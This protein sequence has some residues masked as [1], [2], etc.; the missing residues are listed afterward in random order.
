[1]KIHVLAAV[2]LGVIV[3]GSHANAASISIL[4]FS[5]ESPTTNN[6]GVSG[7]SVP[8]WAYS[9]STNASGVYAPTSTQYGGVNPFDG[10]Q[11]AYLQETST[12]TISQVLATTVAPN[13]VYTLS[14]LLGIRN[15]RPTDN[16]LSSF[17]GAVTAGTTVFT[18]A[19]TTTAPVGDQFK[20]E[21]YTFTTGATVNTGAFLTVT[22]SGSVNGSGE[23]D[24]DKVTLNSASTTTVP[25]PPAV[26]TGMGLLGV[27]GLS[28]VARRKGL[29][30]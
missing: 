10:T 24:Y 26:W 23:Y 19:S 27:L 30:V 18:T 15:D 5:F 12:T 16:S 7:P 29:T 22:L 11:V 6:G 9:N 17:S 3:A 13:T 28:M 4:N 25:L 21:T 14:F 20:L 1:M 8:N 2:A